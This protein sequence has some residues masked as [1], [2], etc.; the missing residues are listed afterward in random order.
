[1]LRISVNQNQKL[2]IVKLEGKLA[3]LWVAELERV[4]LSLLLEMNSTPISLDLRDLNF[5]DKGGRNL[6]RQIHM[7]SGAEF[8]ADSPL[9]RSYAEEASNGFLNGH[10]RTN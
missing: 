9:T 3:G 1:M 5:A 10:G 8:L 2:C 6:L 4:W 7:Q